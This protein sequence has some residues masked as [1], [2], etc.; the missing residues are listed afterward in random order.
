M[1]FQQSVLG[2][3]VAAHACA[4][5]LKVELT[6]SASLNLYFSK[7]DGLEGE[8]AQQRHHYI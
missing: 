7:R 6:P 3:G 1:R 5:K 4:K 2:V 8:T